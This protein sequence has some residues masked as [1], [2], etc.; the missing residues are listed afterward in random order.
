MEKVVDDPKAGWIC[1]FTLFTW[2]A[3]DC[4]ARVSPSLIA[5]LFGRFGNPAD[6]FRVYLPPSQ[7]LS[8]STKKIGFSFVVQIFSLNLLVLRVLH[9]PRAQFKVRL[10]RVAFFGLW[11]LGLVG[12]VGT[13][14]PR[15]R[16][17]MLFC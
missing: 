5:E 16:R 6:F 12:L 10:D 4:R 7:A 11:L 14:K 17:G 8:I 15:W 3:G 1:Q 9:A 13:K 2:L